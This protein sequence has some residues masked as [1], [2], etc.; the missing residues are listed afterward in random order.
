MAMSSIMVSQF[1]NVI[2]HNGQKEK[3]NS[4]LIYA[5][6]AILFYNKNNQNKGKL[7]YLIVT[8]NQKSTANTCIGATLD[9]SPLDWE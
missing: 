5:E 6:N 2:T 1:I 9:V 3:R 4:M 8:T 7:S